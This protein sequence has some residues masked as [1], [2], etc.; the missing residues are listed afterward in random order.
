MA[1]LHEGGRPQVGEITCLGGGKK[2]FR[3][4]MQSYNPAFRGAHSQ[5]Y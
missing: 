4:D 2:I 3:V 5:D 1:W